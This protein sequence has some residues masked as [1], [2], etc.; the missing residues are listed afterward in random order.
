MTSCR[1]E[2]AEHSSAAAREYAARVAQ[3]TDWFDV[4]S[5]ERPDFT[6]S[7]ITAR[8]YR[9]CKLAY[10]WFHNRNGY[11]HFGISRDGQLKPTD[12]EEVVRIVGQLIRDTGTKKV[13]ELA[14]GQGANLRYLAERFP[15]VQFVG[16]DLPN[17]QIDQARKRLVRMPNVRLV[18]GNYHDLSQFG[19]AEF[20]VAFIVEG[21]CHSST[22]ALFFAQLRRVL[23]PGG[24]FMMSDGY[25]ARE[26]V[27]ETERVGRLFFEGGM[28]LGGMESYPAV[29]EHARGQRFTVVG[30]EDVSLMVLPSVRRIVEL[31]E[32]FF[33]HQRL[34]K[35]LIALLPRLLVANAATAYLAALTGE[36]GLYSYWVTTLR[37]D[38]GPLV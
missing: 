28:A 24:L 31:G 8:Y 25:R 35:A 22:K 26:P 21:L 16:L 34:A 38:D 37:N 36:V 6:D 1:D 33:R 7:K 29:V 12:Y 3:L 9:V 11:V 5:F 4:N 20:G 10:R 27:N 13:L 14:T 2:A 18:E 32:R 15:D 17:G 23:E 19:V 30:D